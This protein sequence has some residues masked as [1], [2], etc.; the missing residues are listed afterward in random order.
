MRLPCDDCLNHL[1]RLHQFEEVG[2]GNGIEEGSNRQARRSQC[3]VS[4]FLLPTHPDIRFDQ[5]ASLFWL[6]QIDS[7]TDILGPLLVLGGA[8]GRKEE[9]VS[10]A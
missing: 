6:S 8:W 10:H 4:P 3:P 1:N 9:A 7:W 5:A 2:P